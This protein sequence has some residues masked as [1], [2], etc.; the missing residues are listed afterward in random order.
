MGEVID[1]DELRK[2]DL[3]RRSDEFLYRLRIFHGPT[4]FH[5][6]TTADLTAHTAKIVRLADEPQ[7]GDDS[8]PAGAPLRYIAQ[9]GR[10]T[11]REIL[12]AVCR[13]YKFDEFVIRGHRRA[14]QIT[15]ARFAF[16]W[17][18]HEHTGWS[19]T[20]IGRF[21]HRDHTSVMHGVNRFGQRLRQDPAL[22][23]D[24]ESLNDLI[25]INRAKAA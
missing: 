8:K 13:F 12:D 17:L 3:I 19:Y 4:A 5:R 16:Y 2:A 23:K 9:S 18:C 6:L 1:L 11:M 24:I 22:Q 10:P 14:K 21:A 20:A 7:E 25:A 15:K